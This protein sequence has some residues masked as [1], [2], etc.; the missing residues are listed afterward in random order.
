MTATTHNT[1]GLVLKIGDGATP[2]EDFTAVGQ[3]TDWDGFDEKSK[4]IDITTLDDDY[5]E[6]DGGAVIDSGSTGMDLLYDAANTNINTLR[7]GVGTKKNFKLIL[8]NGT[9]QFAFA[10]VITGYK[11]T[12]KK[13]DKVRAKVSLDISGAITKS[14]ITP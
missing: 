6:K 13:D 10:A 12:G 9:T 4:V 5:A 3:I 8:S 1:N 14:T 11:I 7:S 2:T